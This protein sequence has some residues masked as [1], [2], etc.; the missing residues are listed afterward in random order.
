MLLLVGP[1]WLIRRRRDRRKLEALREADRAIERRERAQAVEALLATVL[2][3]EAARI[4]AED[5]PP[6]A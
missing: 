4:S 5:H 1:V 2:A 3:V 6:S